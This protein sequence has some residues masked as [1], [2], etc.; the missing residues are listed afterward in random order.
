[1]LIDDDWSLR[2]NLCQIL[3]SSGMYATSFGD[4]MRALELLRIGTMRPDV[5]VVDVHLPIVTGLDLLRGLREEGISIPS[6]LISGLRM[7]LSRE[8]MDGIGCRAYLEKPFGADLFLRK[9]H[10]ILPASLADAATQGI[11]R[12]QTMARGSSLWHRREFMDPRAAWK[13]GETA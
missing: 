13:E 9:I 10:E 6:L 4:A 8:Q 2:Q 11:E 7:S 5:L 1:M 3:D 12:A